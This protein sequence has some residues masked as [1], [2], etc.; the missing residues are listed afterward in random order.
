MEDY[1]KKA[2]KKEAA[3]FFAELPPP[4]QFIKLAREAAQIFK[5]EV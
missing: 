3:G 1:N 5:R 4:D 2:Q